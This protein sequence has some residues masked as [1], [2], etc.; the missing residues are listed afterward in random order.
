MPGG[1]P[2]R[3]IAT[4]LSLLFL[5]CC[6]LS[7]YSK[8]EDDS[9]SVFFDMTLYGT[10]FVSLFGL[11]YLETCFGI[12]NPIQPYILI[13]IFCYSVTFSLRFYSIISSITTGL[14]RFFISIPH[15]L[16]VYDLMALTSTIQGLVSLYF[17]IGDPRTVIIVRLHQYL[18]RSHLSV[19]TY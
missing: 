2:A 1:K 5:H 7:A 19:Y 13:R 15:P 14:P 8:R 16:F 18:V 11:F 6:P 12:Q 9:H 4:P 3:F 10:T 17:S